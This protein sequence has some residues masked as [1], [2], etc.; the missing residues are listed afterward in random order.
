MSKLAMDLTALPPIVP[1]DPPTRRVNNLV[2][3]FVAQLQWTDKAESGA[4]GAQRE[5]GEKSVELEMRRGQRPIRR[6]VP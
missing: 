4:S 5:D 2:D 3:A 6:R 1:R